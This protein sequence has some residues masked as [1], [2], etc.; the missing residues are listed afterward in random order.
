MAVRPGRRSQHDAARDA[1]P[2]PARGGRSAAVPR[3]PVHTPCT[4]SCRHTDTI[5][6]QGADATTRGEPNPAYT[7]GR[8]DAQSRNTRTNYASCRSEPLMGRAAPLRG[9]SAPTGT[10]QDGSGGGRPARPPPRADGSQTSPQVARRA[11]RPRVWEAP[12]AGMRI[13]N[14]SLS[15]GEAH[16]D[17]GF[18]LDG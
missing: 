18:Q 12:E 14:P 4:I 5:A 13:V 17:R 1:H 6:P 8:H 16:R 3:A 15:R 10:W 2:T 11:P 7:R 9:S